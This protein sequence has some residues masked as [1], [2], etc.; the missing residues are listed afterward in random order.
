M[1]HMSVSLARPRFGEASHNANQLGQPTTVFQ[2]AVGR[3]FVRLETS[4]SHLSHG[5]TI[6]VLV[7]F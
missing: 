2:Q 7:S 6:A 3:L 1:F 5:V 4:L